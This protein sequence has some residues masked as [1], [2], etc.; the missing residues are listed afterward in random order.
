MARLNISIPDDLRA[1]M[2]GL[3]CNWSEI[4]QGAFANAVKVEELKHEGNNVEAGLVRLRESKQA[5][6][7][8]EQAEGFTHGRHWALEEA[9]YDELKEIVSAFDHAQNNATRYDEALQALK[10]QI[11]GRH[12]CIPGWDIPA[13]SIAYVAG[14]AEGV[15]DV[16]HKI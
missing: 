6:S 9:S 13:P 2:E 11:T 5:N 7:D 10:K 3:N 4:A 14:Y 15:E 12:I 8:R 16:F 1:S